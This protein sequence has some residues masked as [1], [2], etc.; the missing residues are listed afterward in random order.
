MMVAVNLTQAEA[1]AL[2]AMEK[3]RSDDTKWSYPDFGGHVTIPLVSID[4]RESFL[5]DLR[6]GRIDLG[7]GIYQN[8]VHP[9]R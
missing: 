6:R 3:H 7:K 4:R 1:D 5:L 2:L 8:R 9:H